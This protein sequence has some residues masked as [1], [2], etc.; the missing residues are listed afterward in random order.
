MKKIFIPLFSIIFLLISHSPV[1]AHPGRTDSSGCHTCR[2]NCASWGLSTGEYH[3]H[4]GST[5]VAPAVTKAPTAA[6]TR[7]Y[8]PTPTRIITPTP[9]RVVT[10]S[11]TKK[12]TPTPTQEITPSA[13]PT[14]EITETPTP[15]V[16]PTVQ[17][18]KVTP[19]GGFWT[20]LARL[21]GGN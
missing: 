10:P 6:P 4:G 17:A 12:I 11:P 3:C 2:T 18:A 16:L 7:V 15:T 21:F 13:K 9:S 20:W 8:T 5:Y 14:Y 1:L 19:R